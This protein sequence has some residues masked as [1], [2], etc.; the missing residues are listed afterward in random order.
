MSDFSKLLG[1]LQD[2]AKSAKRSEASNSLSSTRKRKICNH[3]EM[4]QI[5]R[6][7]GLEEEPK[8][9]R[10][11]DYADLSVQV[12]FLCIGAQKVRLRLLK[13]EGMFSSDQCPVCVFASSSKCSQSTI[14]MYKAGT[15][16][17]HEMLKRHQGIA[18]PA[19]KEVHFWDWHRA[20]GLRWY[21]NQFPQTFQNNILGEIT[22]CYAVLKSEQVS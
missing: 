6:R 22:P 4:Q 3:S 11:C 5:I 1:K 14:I 17:L 18:L 2:T 10:P 9:K 15:T 13:C 8:P 16:W 12:S 20:R 21:S 19:Q 7:K